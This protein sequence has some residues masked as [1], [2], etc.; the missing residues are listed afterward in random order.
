MPGTPATTP[1]LALP[2]YSNADPADFATD[3]NAITD[4][5]DI[6]SGRIVDTYTNRPAASTALN[7]L[8]FFA[9][10]K[11]IEWQCV[12][13][14]WVLVNVLAPEVTSLPASPIDQQECVLLSDATN[15]VKWHLRYRAASASVSKWELVGGGSLVASNTAGGTRASGGGFGA[16]SG[17]TGPSI[18]APLRGD[19]DIAFGALIV[20]NSPGARSEIGVQIGAGAVTDNTA[21]AS[22]DASAAIS[23]WREIRR[24]VSA[25]STV[26]QTVFSSSA[27]IAAFS[28]MEL[29]V[30]PVRVG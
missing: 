15:G 21:A 25:A 14:A 7:G 28:E 2:R 13:G 4:R 17:T 11:A 1:R 3:V 5:L 26:I 27:S 19:Y 20:N 16:L 10:D 9:S 24:P 12:A 6:V 23:A 29:R 22:E 18:V 30:R 8:S